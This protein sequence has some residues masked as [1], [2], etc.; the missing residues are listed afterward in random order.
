MLCFCLK[1]KH[2]KK[3]LQKKNKTKPILGDRAVEV[4]RGSGPTPGSPDAEMKSP[5]AH[6]K[7]LELEGTGREGGPH[8][9]KTLFPWEFT[10]PALEW[11]LSPGGDLKN[12][13]Q[14]GKE[15][16]HLHKARSQEFRVLWHFWCVK[17][18]M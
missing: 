15:G 8:R 18:K 3:N 10:H 7:G 13:V 5:Q 1:K 2:K 14:S 9:V 11:S 12:G 4:Q 6:L 17:T 16:Q